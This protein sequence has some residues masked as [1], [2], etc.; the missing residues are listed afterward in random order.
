[1][2][3]VNSPLTRA[4]IPFFFFTA[5]EHFPVQEDQ[6]DQPESTYQTTIETVDGQ[7]MDVYL[8]WHNFVP[9]KRAQSDPDGEGASE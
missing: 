4:T 6:L 2:R 5:S 1:M 9:V 8:P 3:L 7:W